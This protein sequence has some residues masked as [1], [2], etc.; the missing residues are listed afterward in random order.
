MESKV[1]ILGISGS[2]RKGSFNSALLREAASL[3]PANATLEVFDV[4]GF[5]LYNT[6]QEVSPPAEVRA[7]KS[8]VKEADAILFATPEFNRSISATL[9][10]A[11]E[12]GNRPPSE[13]VWEGKPAAVVSASSGPRGGARAQAVLRQIMVDLDIY[14]INGPELFLGKAQEAFD[15]DLRLKDER[16]KE[17]LRVLL[18]A[19]VEWTV[20]LRGR[21]GSL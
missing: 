20:L 17:T 10:N 15:Q 14:P 4:S 3:V 7:F 1:K 21:S 8:K 16:T 19:L 11:L 12:W 5:P 9:K 13:D 18:K 6:D 2:G